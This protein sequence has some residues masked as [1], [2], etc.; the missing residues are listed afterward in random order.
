MVFISIPTPCHEKWNE[1]LP[2]ERGAF[3]NICAKTVVDFTRLN[4]EEVRNYFFQNRHQK[5]C[6]RFRN[7]QLT[8]ADNPLPQLLADSLP[9]W[10]KFLAIVLVVFGS[11]LTGCNNNQIGKL[12]ASTKT[13]SEKLSVTSGVT[14]VDIQQEQIA[15]T[16][17]QECTATMGV[18]DEIFGDTAIT[19]IECKKE[20]IPDTAVGFIV[21]DPAQKRELD[22]NGNE[23]KYRE[24]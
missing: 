9:F 5:T 19:E 6:G 24:Q 13:G 3:C 17:V 14:L 21:I 1:M 7:D 18:I 20:E 2:N 15:D 11:L 22:E 10:K 16:A 4:D 8:D 12:E 23:K